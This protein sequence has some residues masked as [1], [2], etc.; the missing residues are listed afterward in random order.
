MVGVGGHFTLQPMTINFPCLGGGGGAREFKRKR[1][2][3]DSIAESS[4]L[5]VWNVT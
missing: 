3:M 1:N 5:H 2:L 4:T